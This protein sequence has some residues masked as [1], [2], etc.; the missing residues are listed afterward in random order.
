MKIA[1]LILAHAEPEQL[2]RLIHKL[3]HEDACFF[4][5]LDKK[6][7]IHYFEFLMKIARVRFIPERVNVRWGAYS[8]VQATINGFRAIQ[9]SGVE[10]GIINLLSGSDYPIKNPKEI[11]NFFKENEGQNFMEFRLV[12]H[13]WEEAIPRITRYHLDNYAFPGKYL[14]QKYLHKL[15]PLRQMPNGLIPVGRSQWMSLTMESVKYILDYLDRNA[16]V[17]SFFR[18]TWAPDEMIFQTILYNSDFRTKIS[19]NNLRYI[20]WAEGKASPK[21]LSMEDAD[22]LIQSGS[23]FAR[24]FDLKAHPELFDF[25]DGIIADFDRKPL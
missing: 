19:N 2:E 3:Q 11:H 5:H 15:A 23:L 4:V 10:I 9:N 22:K 20:D 8:I 6:A 24:K 21:T 7:D 14:L 18:L 25:I 17:A 12:Y 1:H 13:E 16:N